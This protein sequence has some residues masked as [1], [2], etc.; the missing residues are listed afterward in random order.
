MVEAKAS[1]PPQVLKLWLGVS[2]GIL[3]AKY[4][5]SYKSSFRSVE[6]HGD[7]GR[8]APIGF[9]GCSVPVFQ[10]LISTTFP[11]HCGRGESTGTTTCLRSMVGVSKDMLPVKDFCSNK[12]FFV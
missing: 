9:S 2:K 6:F 8:G 4:S 10:S 12:A 5:C 11:K 3:T 1:G 7:Q